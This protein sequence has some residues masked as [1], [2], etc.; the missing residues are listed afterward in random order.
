MAYIND[1]KTAE[2]RNAL[3][4]ILRASFDSKQ[5]DRL[6][7]IVRQVGRIGGLLSQEKY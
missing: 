1:E 6:E 7:D 3:A 4:I 2:I 5:Q